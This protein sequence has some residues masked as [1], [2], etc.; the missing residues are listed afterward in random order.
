MPITPGIALGEYHPWKVQG[1]RN[2]RFNWYCGYL[3]ALKNP[4]HADH[5]RAVRHLTQL[6]A[7][8]LDTLVLDE[9]AELVI[10]PGHSAGGASAGLERIVASVV[11]GDPRLSYRKGALSRSKTI[12]KLSQGGP[13]ATAVHSASMK[14]VEGPRK[15]RRKILFDDITTTGNSLLAGAALIRGTN[16]YAALSALVLGKTVH[17]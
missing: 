1:L 7:A 14:Y 12:A 16:P 9:G 11:K 2:P 8:Y 15:V 6:T 17:G 4:E 5:N 3:L 13:R 10:I